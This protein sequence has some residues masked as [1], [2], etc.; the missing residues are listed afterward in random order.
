MTGSQRKYKN[1]VQCVL[2]L[3]LVLVLVI[4]DLKLVGF[5]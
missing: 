1:Q 4:S 3:V 5:S 2:V